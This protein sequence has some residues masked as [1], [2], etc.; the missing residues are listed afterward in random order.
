MSDHPDR[1]SEIT[2]RS[3]DGLEV[4]LMWERETDA[5]VVAVVDWKQGDAFDVA[6]LPGERPLDVFAHPFAY[7]ALHRDR[8][9]AQVAAPAGRASRPALES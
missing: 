6:V 5:L 3:A 9:P 7:A 8:P 4:A 2:R 1:F